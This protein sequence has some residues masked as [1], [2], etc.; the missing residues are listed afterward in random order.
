MP[1]AAVHPVPGREA[2]VSTGPVFRA[3]GP[4]V[5]AAAASP[6]TAPGHPREAAAG[7]TLTRRAVTAI[8]A[9]VVTMTFAFSL[10]NVTRLC[11]ALGIKGWIA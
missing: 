2:P 6:R 1:D 9:S 5:P 4:Q 8:T 10:G 7:E 11:I 3:P